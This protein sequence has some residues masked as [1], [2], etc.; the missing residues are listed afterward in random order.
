MSKPKIPEMTC[1][2]GCHDCCGA[3]PFSRR[4][5]RQVHIEAQ[6]RGIKWMELPDDGAAVPYGKTESLVCPFLGQNGCTIYEKRP[7]MCRLFGHVDHPRM[8][9]PH[10]CGD[11][12]I[13]QEESTAMVEEE[14]AKE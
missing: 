5:Q 14:W 12:S 8:K 7:L 11:T 1:I 6:M 10:G 13:T 3:P 2:P 4:E 9:C